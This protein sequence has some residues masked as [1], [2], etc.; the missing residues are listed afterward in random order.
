MAQTG[1][2]FSLLARITFPL[3]LWDIWR[4]YLSAVKLIPV[5]FR[6]P[7]VRE[8]VRGPGSQITVPLGEVANEQILQE[9]LR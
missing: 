6:E 8:D 5:D 1:K 2:V 7:S 9:L 3:N 4:W